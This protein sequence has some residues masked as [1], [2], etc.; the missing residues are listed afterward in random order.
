MYDFCAE[1]TSDLLEYRLGNWP[2]VLSSLSSFPDV[3][4]IPALTDQATILWI[5]TPVIT[6]HVYT[7]LFLWKPESTLQSLSDKIASKYTQKAEVLVSK[8]ELTEFFPGKWV[9]FLGFYLHIHIEHF[10]FYSPRWEVKWSQKCEVGPA[11]AKMGAK[12]GQLN[13]WLLLSLVQTTFITGA[14]SCITHSSEECLSLPCH[15]SRAGLTFP[16]LRVLGGNTGRAKV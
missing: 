1:A 6:Y 8:Q 4:C 15:T 16:E 13:F 14:F 10:N 5:L 2:P 7:E 3:F 9:V 11:K 12:F